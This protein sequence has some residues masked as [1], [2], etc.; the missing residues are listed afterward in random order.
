MFKYL[1]HLPFS[2]IYD[3]TKSILILNLILLFFLLLVYIRKIKYN[4]G[5]HKF[6][7][8]LLFMVLVLMIQN[9]YGLF[10][11]KYANELFVVYSALSAVA[12]AGL[13]F[14]ELAPLKRYLK[15]YKRK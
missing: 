10:Y 14:G 13:L 3:I 6:L 4:K 8:G 1:K 12:L 9:T 15:E 2:M 7:F 11:V 5:K